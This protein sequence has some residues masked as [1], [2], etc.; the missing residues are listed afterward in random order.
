MIETSR[1]DAGVSRKTCW[2]L[3]VVFVIEKHGV[4]GS[5]RHMSDLTRIGRSRVSARG[6]RGSCTADRASNLELWLVGHAASSP[7]TTRPWF[8]RTHAAIDSG[9]ICF[10]LHLTESLGPLSRILEPPSSLLTHEDLKRRL[11]LP[12]HRASPSIVYCEAAHAVSCSRSTW[13]KASI[14]PSLPHFSP[15]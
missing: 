9:F 6:H 14:R 2:M 1:L 5:N 3:S 11:L 13:P 4:V 12:F 7:T 8:L 15:S 10:F